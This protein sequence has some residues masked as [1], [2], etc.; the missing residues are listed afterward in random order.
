M[1]LGSLSECASK[2]SER[3]KR[4]GARRRTTQNA[5][6]GFKSCNILTACDLEIVELGWCSGITPALGTYTRLQEVISSI[7]VPG[8]DFCRGD[9]NTCPFAFLPFLF[10]T[11]FCCILDI[12]DDHF[13][14]FQWIQALETSPASAEARHAYRRRVEEEGRTCKGGQA[15]WRSAQKVRG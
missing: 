15:I 9:L 13:D 3:A 14:S 7:L 4:Q 12:T 5:S 8:L 11:F 2:V 10:L 1:G 6:K